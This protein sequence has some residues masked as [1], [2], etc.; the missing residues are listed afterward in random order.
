MFYVGVVSSFTGTVNAEK[1]Q[2]SLLEKLGHS[3]GRAKRFLDSHKP[4]DVNGVMHRAIVCVLSD[5]FRL[6]NEV[7]GLAIKQ[8]QCSWLT[9]KFHIY[10]ISAREVMG[11]KV[12]WVDIFPEAAS[13]ASTPELAPTETA[14]NTNV[15]VDPVQALPVAS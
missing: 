12:D 3:H 15:S 14:V 1:T 7:I 5:R 4:H 11:N 9:A 8:Y 6:N 13:T 2:V 10:R